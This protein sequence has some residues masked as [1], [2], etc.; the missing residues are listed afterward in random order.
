MTEEVVIEVEHPPE[1]DTEALAEAIVDAQVEAAHELQ[2]EAEVEAA[3][4]ISEAALETA[5]EALQTT[6][7]HDH[8]EYSPVGHMHPEYA[9]SES[10]SEL[11]GRVAA[12]E[13]LAV[14]DTNEPVVE[15]VE[16]TTEPRPTEGRRRRFSFGKR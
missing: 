4:E 3:E 11:E 16:P 15:E 14:E 7:T 5:Q 12:L 8:P 2:Q 10:V 9:P 6:I 1:S 13:A